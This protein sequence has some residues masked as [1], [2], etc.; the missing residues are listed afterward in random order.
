MSKACVGSRRAP[1]GNHANAATA[2]ESHHADS[3]AVVSVADDRGILQAQTCGWD[4]PPP[5][6][7]E[8]VLWG[9]ADKQGFELVKKR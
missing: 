5:E 6:G 3:T 4:P 1:A 7:A 9:W 8:R 2:V